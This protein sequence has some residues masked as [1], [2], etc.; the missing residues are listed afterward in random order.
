MKKE[1]WLIG[2]VILL[3]FVFV[4]T[5]KTSKQPKEVH[6]HAGFQVYV[7][8]KRQDFLQTKYMSVKPCEE[9]EH[10]ELSKEEIQEEKAHLHE[11]VG[12]VV[13]VH[14]EGATWGDLF[15]NIRYD[16]PR[17][18]PIEAFVNGQRVSNILA[19]FI[20]PYDSAVIFLGKSD[21][22]LLKSAVSK[23]RIKKVEQS[24]VDC[25]GNE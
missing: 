22:R 18:K 20:G 21:Q 23:E 14:L 12:D 3:G 6:I 5:R 10:R 19:R 4:F 11:N 15:K 17:S 2:I 7:D 24:S 8:G 1:L 13:H 25:G 9:G 16:F